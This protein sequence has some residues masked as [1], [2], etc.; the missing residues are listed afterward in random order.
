MYYFRGHFEQKSM[1]VNKLP[2]GL[3]INW[4]KEPRI[5]FMK[6]CLMVLVL[7]LKLLNDRYSDD[8]TYG[9]I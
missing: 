4:N 5:V 3:D 8:D 6:Y 9:L 2:H 1:R 7:T